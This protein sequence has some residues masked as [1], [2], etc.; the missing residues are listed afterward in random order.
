MTPSLPDLLIGQAASL[1]APQPPEAGGDYLAGR[2]AMLAML[3]ALMGQEAERGVAARVWE[4]HAI[5]SLLARAA[6]AYDPALAGPLG[7]DDGNLAWSD[8][9]RRNADLRRRLITLH[10]M[11]EARDDVG[12]DGEILALYRAMAHARRLDLPAT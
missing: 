6:P 2:L 12:L 4:N 5:Q 10:E 7:P 3:A 8:L 9:D 11:V 1:A